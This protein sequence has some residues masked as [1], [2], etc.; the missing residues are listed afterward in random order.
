VAS[1]TKLSAH[2]RAKILARVSDVVSKNHIKRVPSWPALVAEHKE[3]IVRVE[4]PA[5]F[6]QAMLDLLENLGMSHTRFYHRSLNRFPAQRCINATL[7]ALREPGGSQV[8]VPRR[9]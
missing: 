1:K 9:T 3:Q 7:S 5:E 2:Q 4:H 6:E 8:D